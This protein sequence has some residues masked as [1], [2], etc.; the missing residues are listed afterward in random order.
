MSG[1]RV[2]WDSKRPPGQRVLSVRIQIHRD[3]DESISSVASS[4]SA[5]PRESEFET[6]RRE[7]GGRIYR[8]VTREYMAEGHDGFTALQGH[9]YLI[10]DEN[11]Q[12]MS[13]LVRKY[14]LGK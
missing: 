8:V 9:K 1:F 10:D 7:M 12:L 6:V 2:E 4:E 13:S 14:L 3:D 5:T 11:G